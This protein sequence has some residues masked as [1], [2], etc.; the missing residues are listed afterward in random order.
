[1]N[2]LWNLEYSWGN[3][4]I[5]FKYLDYVKVNHFKHL[6]KG[7]DGSSIVAMLNTLFHYPSFVN[8]E[9]NFSMNVPVT[10]EELNEAIRDIN[11][12][13]SI[14]SI[15]SQWI[16]SVFMDLFQENLLLVIAESRVKV[17]NLAKLQYLQDGVNLTMNEY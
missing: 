4:I 9:H 7:N 6:C 8:E 3:Q 5:G 10:L 12:D 1:M 11:I 14:N 17:F 16:F 2:A 13:E 15:V